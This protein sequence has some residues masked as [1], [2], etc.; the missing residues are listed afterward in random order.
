MRR[1]A[2]VIVMGMVRSRIRVREG[3]LKWKKREGKREDAG[4]VRR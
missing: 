1:E 2:E 4:S 3:D